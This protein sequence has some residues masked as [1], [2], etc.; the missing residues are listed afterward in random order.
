MPEDGAFFR[1][2]AVATL[3][4]MQQDLMLDNSFLSLIQTAKDQDLNN[5]E[6]AIIRVLDRDILK[7]QKVP[8]QLI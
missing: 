8:K 5:Y 2:K 6:Q 7:Y 1:G 4:S 3:S